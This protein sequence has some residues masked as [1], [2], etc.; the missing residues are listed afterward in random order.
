M[1]LGGVV[2]ADKNTGTGRVVSKRKL[3]ILEVNLPVI[4]LARK[5]SVETRLA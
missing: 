4:A 2:A 5:T 1:C 3:S